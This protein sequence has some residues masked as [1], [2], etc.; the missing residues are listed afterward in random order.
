MMSIRF[1]PSLSH[2]AVMKLFFFSK[3]IPYVNLFVVPYNISSQVDAP[4]KQIVKIRKSIGLVGHIMR[5]VA[6]TSP[7]RIQLNVGLYFLLGACLFCVW[8]YTVCP[9]NNF[10]CRICKEDC[11]VPTTVK[12]IGSVFVRIIGMMR[13]LNDPAGSCVP[14]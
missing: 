14:P 7:H 12:S 5:I 6:Y 1:F 11:A 13:A 4:S 9:Y 8:I 3:F 2:T 10:L